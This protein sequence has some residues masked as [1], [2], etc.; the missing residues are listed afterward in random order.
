MHDVDLA[1]GE[2]EIVSIIGA[3]GAGKS[4]L[5]KAIVGQAGRVDRLG[6][7]RRRRSVRVSTPRHRRQGHRAGAGGPQAL[8]VADRVEE[9]LRIGWEV[10]RK[11]EIGFDE[12]CE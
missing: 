2:G 11:G 10:G 5:L 4:S 12:V 1:V 9:N 8:S 3:N 7:L 6:A